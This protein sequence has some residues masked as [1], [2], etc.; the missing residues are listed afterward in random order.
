MTDR[1]SAGVLV[2][3]RD[4]HGTVLV[5]L[6][7]MGGPFW[8]RKDAG[9]LSIPKGEYEPDAEESTVAARRE[10]AEELG[11][12]V[13]EGPW[14]PLGEVRYGSGRGRK[15]LTAWAVA[16]DLDPAEVVPGTFEM[17]WPPRSG[18]TATFPEIDRV[19]WFDLPTAHDKLVVGQ[20]PYLDRLADRL[21]GDQDHS[22]PVISS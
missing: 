18:R 20:R 19:D 16:G 6:G 3:R 8:A 1:H 21:R 10:F 2:F 4:E 14:I 12:P 5:L 17:E 7:H 9:A 11:V 22:R 13:P 15:V